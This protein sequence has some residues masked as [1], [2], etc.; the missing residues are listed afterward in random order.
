MA[1]PEAI[2]VDL[3]GLPPPEPLERIL[4]AVEADEI[5]STFLL[6]MEPLPLFVLLRHAGVRYRV[7]RIE[8]GV[9]ITLDRPLRKA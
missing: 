1:I 9:E 4:R 6:A 7:R 3:R 5:P 8:E 2:R